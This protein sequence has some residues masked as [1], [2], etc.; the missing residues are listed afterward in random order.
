M[1]VLGQVPAHQL[2][3]S[4]GQH[5]GTVH[6]PAPVCGTETRQVTPNSLL[7]HFTV[8]SAYKEPTYKEL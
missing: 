8:D 4:P 7:C 1:C 3:G 5:V 6:Q 2:P